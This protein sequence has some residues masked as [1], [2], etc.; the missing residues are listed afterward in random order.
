MNQDKT[1]LG[2]EPIGKGLFCCH[3]V[4]KAVRN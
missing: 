4:N 2:T 1:F 3:F